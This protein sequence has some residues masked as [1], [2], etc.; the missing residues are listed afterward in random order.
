M[1]LFVPLDL[2]IVAGTYVEFLLLVKDNK[3]PKDEE[4]NE[5]FH[6]PKAIKPIKKQT[7]G[8]NKDMCHF[9][10]AP[11][12]QSATVKVILKLVVLID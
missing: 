12:G 9:S 5:V 4:S 1:N 10:E 8:Q 7:A 11:S 3:V 2:A 6:H